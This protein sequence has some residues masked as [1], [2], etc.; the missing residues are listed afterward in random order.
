MSVLSDLEKLHSAE[1]FFSYLKVD[2]DPSVVRV[3]RLHI[4]K[5]MGKYFAEKDLTGASED[6]VLSGA[7]EMLSQA[8]A[9]FVSSRPI[10]ERV[11]KVLQE[12]DPHRPASSAGSASK[13]FVP[14]DSLTI[15]GR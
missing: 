2:F 1:D 11:F 4:L 13:P 7:R 14:L 8:Y 9:D 3:A 12:H 5:R 15:T 6:A 10:D